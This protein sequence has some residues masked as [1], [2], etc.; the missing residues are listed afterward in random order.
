MKTT[1][2]NKKQLR[3]FFSILMVAGLYMNSIGQTANIEPWAANQLM[4]PAELAR[5]I[6]DKNA[7]QPIVLSI[8]P[9]AIIK[10]SV[11]IGPA[12]KKENLAKLKAKI[13][14]LPKD[15]KIVIYCGCCPFGNCPNIRPAF[16]LLKEMK[17]TN[18][19]LLNLQ[20]NIKVDWIDRGYPVTK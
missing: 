14:K 2:I 10:G 11:D 15:A 16:Q 1:M 5:I 7:H 6:K 20:Q 18:Q 13:S 4:P 17:F 8:G 3:L 12:N 19:K 9:G